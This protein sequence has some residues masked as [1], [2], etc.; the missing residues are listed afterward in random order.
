MFGEKKKKKKPKV[1]DLPEPVPEQDVED[2]AVPDVDGDAVDGED[3][4]EAGENDDQG[5]EEPA[6]EISLTGEPVA[7]NEEGWLGS[8]RDYEYGELLSRMYRILR[9]N[10]PEL[11]GEKRR[12]TI[13][14]PQVARE[15]SKK[16]VFSNVSDI[17]RRMKRTPE[18]LIQFVFAEL[19][20]SGSV[21]GSGQLIIKGRFQPKQIET[22]LKRYIGEYVT[23]K[24]CKSFETNI[25]RDNRLWFI[26]CESCGSRRTVAAISAG[27]KAQTTKRAKM[28]AA[29]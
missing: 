1:E 20:T 4:Q 26:T 6:G 28:R 3:E 22:V 5:D 23:C 9:E 11:I 17:A 18:H 8:E 13:P 21:D 7:G 2:G 15:G 25:S 10:N 29:A 16:T 27:F 19:G 24:T 14:P 12:Y